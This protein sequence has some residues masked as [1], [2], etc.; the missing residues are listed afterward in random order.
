MQIGMARHNWTEDG[1][2]QGDIYGYGLK[3]AT[4]TYPGPT[5]LVSKGTPIDVTWHNMLRGP[6]LLEDAVE[7]TL[8]LRESQCFPNCGIPVVVHVHGLES[9]A[10][11]DGLPSHSIYENQSQH[12]QYLND[13]SA[14]TKSYHDHA[15][16]LSRL[17]TWAGLGGAYIIQDETLEASYNVTVDPAWDIPLVIADRLITHDGKLRYSDDFC[18]ENPISKWVPESF[19]FTNVVN[20]RVMP[21]VEVPQAQVRFR[22]IVLAN[23]RHYIFKIPFADRCT[24]IAKDTGFVQHPQVIPQELT[25]Y[26]FERVE[27]IC[28]FSKEADGERFDV[29][30]VEESDLEQYDPRVFQVR[31]SS[32][33]TS[34]T[35]VRSIPSTL[36]KLKDLRQLWKDTNGKT[37]ALKLGEMEFYPTCPSRSMLLFHNQEINVT[38][39]GTIACT[40]GTVERWVFRNPTDDPHPFH[41][42]LVNAQCGPDDDS[43]DTNGM[44]DVV[45]IPNLVEME[46]KLKDLPTQI[47]YVACTPDEFLIEGST[48]GPKEYRFDTSEPYVAHCHILEHE[49]NMMMSWFKILE[50]DDSPDDDGSTPDPNKITPAIIATAMGMSVLGG[51]ATCVSVLVLSVP[52]LQFLTSPRSLAIAFSLSAGVMVFIAFA[53]LFPEAVA[54]YR[55]AFT[56]GGGVDPEAYEHGGTQTNTAICDNTCVGKAWLATAG[57]FYAGVLII[58][59]VEF[60]VHKIFDHHGT[61]ESQAEVVSPAL[62]HNLRADHNNDE[63]EKGRM[64][65]TASIATPVPGSPVAP[66]NPLESPV[67]NESSDLMDPNADHKTSFKRA[68]II[69][70]IAVAIHNFPEGLALFVASLGG[71]RAGIVLS[72]GIILH[73]LPEGVAV[74]AP[75]YYATGS[76]FEA[77]KWTFLSGVAQPLG[78]AVGWAAVSQ[79][80]SVGLQ[81]TL[82]ALVGGMLM[83]IT[84][85]EL[86]PGAFRFDPRGKVF[87]VWLF[88]GVGIIAG[89]LIFLHYEGSA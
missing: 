52:Q 72:F 2:F 46:D 42:H 64:G 1:A 65:K 61:G 22:W 63:V 88:L 58:V 19:G 44:K 18:A 5:L 83:C 30:D 55:A 4:P 24:L 40:R 12:A 86:I 80:M 73:N 49:E 67:G 28:D 35:A 51:L 82:Y 8:N 21:Y 84:A 25:M 69:T 57:A 29:V 41:W 85:H 76:K 39:M 33:L 59:A 13:Q 37:R 81:A 50:H 3:N 34:S 23:A 74:A 70:G 16:G 53:D 87:A 38:N 15:M 75:V 36:T 45:V 77:F 54:F 31:V 71:V 56:P 47:C 10:K 89:S 26:P 43:I 66:V 27:M 78:A 48:R 20:G 9:P 32:K 11:Y 14:S 6:H 62:S 7:S 17:N 60:I 79:G 68:G